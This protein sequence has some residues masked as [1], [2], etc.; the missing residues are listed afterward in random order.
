MVEKKNIFRIKTVSLALLVLTVSLYATSWTK[1]NQKHNGC[2]NRLS[3]CERLYQSFTAGVTRLES[4]VSLSGES[5][6]EAI[7]KN[8]GALQN[9]QEYIKNRID[10][11]QKMSEKISNDISDGSSKNS[12]CPDCIVSSVGL[13]CRQ[14]ESVLSELNELNSQV[15]E[16]ENSF[17]R[18]RNAETL[19]QKNRKNS[20]PN[21]NLKKQIDSALV[22]FE[23]THNQTAKIILDKGVEYAKKGTILFEKGKTKEAEKEM[24]IARELIKQSIDIMSGE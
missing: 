1:V 17:K 4:F 11:L 20:D 14:V 24:T 23:I 12:G 3:R 15:N 22:L 7:E 18:D 8:I 6:Y 5:E 10:R 16:H 2:V 19:L 21:E 13:L 9:K